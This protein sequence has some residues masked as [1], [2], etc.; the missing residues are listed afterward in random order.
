MTAASVLVLALLGGLVGL[1]VVSFPQA[2]ISRPI[3]AATLG[4]ALLG[5]AIEGL[6][7]GVV[8]ELLALE[9]LPFGA[10]WYPEWASASVVGGALFASRSGPAAG[11]L[12]LAL[13]A[14]VATAW[15]GG[16][17]MQSL[18]RLN[19][20]W[21]RRNLSSID[22]G[23]ATTVLTLQLRGLA[24]DFLRGALLTGVAYALLHPALAVVGV[25]W[26]LAL[27]ISCAVAV[28]VAAA[29][30]GSAA[31]ERS[32]GASAA[33]WYLVGGLVIGLATLVLQ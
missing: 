27:G 21:A 1:D 9:T 29:V 16:W 6:L 4:G 25:H 11:T 10:S 24:A 13:L 22:A 5:S 23:N 18:R 12:A 17:T 2:M 3:V 33:R 19:G 32:R 14:A 26:H 30:A 31:W 20:H 15:V 7:V 8:L 28:G